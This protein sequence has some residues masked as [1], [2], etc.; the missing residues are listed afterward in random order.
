MTDEEL[1]AA[2]LATIERLLPKQ[3]EYREWVIKLPVVGDKKP[4][5]VRITVDMGDGQGLREVFCDATW[6]AVC[7]D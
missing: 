7:D 2:H 5:I 3:N 4:E 1:L 6:N